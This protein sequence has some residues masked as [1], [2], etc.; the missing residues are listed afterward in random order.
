MSDAARAADPFTIARDRALERM[1]HYPSTAKIDEVRRLLVAHE[2]ALERGLPSDVPS[3]LTDMSDTE[4]FD[5]IQRI[6]PNASVLSSSVDEFTGT[7]SLDPEAKTL[8]HVLPDEEVF[9]GPGNPFGE[10]PPPRKQKRWWEADEDAYEV[11]ELDT[12]PE[13]PEGHLEQMLSE[14]V[15]QRPADQPMP[16]RRPDQPMEPI[17]A[18]VA[19]PADPLLELAEVPPGTARPPRE[20]IMPFA[21]PVPPPPR[22]LRDEARS[23]LGVGADT[24]ALE[25]AY[26]RR[27]SGPTADY[28]LSPESEG[29]RSKIRDSLAS[30]EGDFYEIDMDTGAF[31][32]LP[33]DD[34]E[35]PAST[36]S[37]AAPHAR[38]TAL[39]DA[40]GSVAG[41]VRELAPKLYD[42]VIA[43]ASGEITDP[44]AVASVAWE[45][46][47]VD[48]LNW[49]RVNPMRQDPEQEL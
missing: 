42:K 49:A 20:P 40:M 7:M 34:G 10:G 36:P 16:R 43:I 24:R 12:P 47:G 28:L 29:Y 31:T 14:S 9:S 3:W 35:E 15:P 18:D 44:T 5:Y 8:D 2:T 37:A 25:R 46:N 48:G 6:E 22:T 23:A 26:G 21:E 11:G 27:F 1:A 39:A 41:R 38:S 17:E 13:A 4:L 33:W 45:L 30:T 32:Q 19:P